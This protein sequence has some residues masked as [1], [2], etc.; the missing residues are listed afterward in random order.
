[1]ADT[2]RQQLLSILRQLRDLCEPDASDHMGRRID[3]EISK[4]EG[5]RLYVV[6]LGQFKR[7]KTSVVNALLED[8]LLPTA[9]TPVTSAVTLIRSGLVRRASVNYAS[10]QTE[11]IA[12]DHLSD[13]LSEQG[14]PGN[15]KGVQFVEILHPSQLLQ[16]GLVLVDTPGIG[17]IGKK[18]TQTT[19]EF[20]PRIDVGIVVFS[21]DPPITEMEM[22]FVK[23]LKGTTSSLLLVMNKID[24]YSPAE[25]SE[26]LNY[27]SA[28]LAREIPDLRVDILPL[29]ARVAL[30]S[31]RDSGDRAANDGKISALRNRLREVLE[32]EGTQV[33]LEQSKKRAASY[34]RDALFVAELEM[35]AALLP[36]RMLEEKARA[37]DEYVATAK[38]SGEEEQILIRGR[39]GTLTRTLGERLE[40]FSKDATVHVRKRILEWRR[41]HAG[42]PARE[43][44]DGLQQ[45]LSAGVRDEFEAWRAEH[46]AQVFSE[47]RMIAS[48]YVQ[49]ANAI[50]QEVRKFSA[51]IF[52]LNVHEVPEPE[53][54]RWDGVFHYKTTDDTSFLEIDPIRVKSALLPGS[55]VRRGLMDQAL[56]SAE[57]KVHRNAG[58][59][60]S[61]YVYAID[62]STRKLLDE[63]WNRMENL[64]V[65]IQVVLKRVLSDVSASRE[66]AVLQEVRAQSKLEVLRRLEHNLE[67]SMMATDRTIPAF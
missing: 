11:Q 7:G 65:Q 48:T 27:V 62:E 8:A 56:A 39:I 37:F 43:F 23:E 60:R 67:G 38:K 5:N 51:N 14:N 40:E 49:E 21:P 31:E 59:L 13:V 19:R 15:V 10:G 46:E 58:R 42:L 6:V 66:S 3:E 34:L 64:V 35:K 32:L 53:V 17:S 18:N 16:G 20:V 52:S 55:I 29:S 1:M 24:A 63:H 9:I 57:D 4:I 22:D 44:R 61:D 47:F 25:A 2:T 41:T 54:I 36:V 28:A 26:A 50:I 12:L 45:A 33:L 30:E